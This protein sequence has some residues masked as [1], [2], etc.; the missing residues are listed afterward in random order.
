MIGFT[1]MG[2]GIANGA[3]VCSNVQVDVGSSGI[4]NV[5]VGQ[6][7][8]ELSQRFARRTAVD[9][10]QIPAK[11]DGVH[12]HQSGGVAGGTCSRHR[13]QLEQVISRGRGLQYK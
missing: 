4:W 13:A 8:L 12:R 1:C 11:E 2:F 6:V 7:L 5:S 10:G 9:L 3:G